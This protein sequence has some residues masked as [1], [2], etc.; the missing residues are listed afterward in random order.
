MRGEAGYRGGGR[1]EAEEGRER[2]EGEKSFM[3]L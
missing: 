1:Q 2:K 3:L